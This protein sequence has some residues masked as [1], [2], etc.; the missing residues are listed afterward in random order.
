MTFEERP[1][2]TKFENPIDEEEAEFKKFI[3]EHACTADQIREAYYRLVGISENKAEIPQVDH[4]LAEMQK[5]NDKGFPWSRFASLIGSRQDFED[6]VPAYHE[7]IETLEIPETEKKVLFSIIDME[8]DG[9]IACLVG[10]RII[11]EF[12]VRTKKVG[13][14]IA[15]AII[16]RRIR[17]ILEQIPKNKRYE[18][19]FSEF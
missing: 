10:N 2:R 4:I 9:E 13:K 15:I 1:R 19:T 5:M 8:K 3:K 16:I 14:S 6:A 11:G 18:F 12:R 17:T 7:Y